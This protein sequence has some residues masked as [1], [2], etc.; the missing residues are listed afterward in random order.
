[1]ATDFL[2]QEMTYQQGV[3]RQGM[4]LVYDDR[5]PK[6]RAGDGPLAIAAST[7][8]RWISRLDG[9]GET[10]HGLCRL[11]REKEPGCELHREVWPVSVRKYRSEPRRQVLQQAVRWIVTERMFVR[12]F[13][14][15]V[16]P[17]F[18]TA[19]GWR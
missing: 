2:G 10:L 14:K 1:M 13:G 3:E 17:H 16:F 19:H 9:L 5:E 7:L 6:T 8:W 12:L 4:S 15:E 18:A 11:I